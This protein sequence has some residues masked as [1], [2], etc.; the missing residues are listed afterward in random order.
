MSRKIAAQSFLFA[1]T[2]AL[3]LLVPKFSNIQSL[4]PP[5][6]AMVALE[7][8]TDEKDNRY[9]I[10]NEILNEI[11]SNKRIKASVCFPRMG[12]QCAEHNTDA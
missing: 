11:S 4:F 6:M 9:I 8:S 1:H 3:S 2:A 10:L 12:K 7:V 5:M